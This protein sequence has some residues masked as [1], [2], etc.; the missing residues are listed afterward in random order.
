MRRRFFIRFCIHFCDLGHLKT[1]CF[2]GPFLDFRGAPRPLRGRSALPHG[3]ETQTLQQARY[4]H[5]ASTVGN[6]LWITG[7]YNNGRLAS[8]EV[9]DPDGTVTYGP[10]LPEA[11][12]YH[13]QVTY[14]DSTFIIGKCVFG[15]YQFNG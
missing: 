12:S 2:L 5:G 8:T 7:G 13:C 11:R 4:D 9:M 10:N 1:T 6:I 14:Q 3:S 15:Q